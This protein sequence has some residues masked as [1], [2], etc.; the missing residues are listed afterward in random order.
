M[1]INYFGDGCFR[2]QSGD[3]TVLVNPINNRLKGDVV[4]KTLT[5][6]DSSAPEQ[7]EVSFPGEYEFKNIEI[8]GWSIANESTEKFLKTVYAITWEDIRCVFLGH[9]SKPL[10]EDFLDE[11]GEP[12]ILF[13]P[14]GDSHFI[15]SADA[16]KLIKQIEPSVIVPAFYKNANDLLKALGQKPSSQEK[17]V[18]K[19]KDLTG[20]KSEV[21]LIESK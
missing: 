13:I 4:I 11:I 2:L 20:M 9:L 7:E 18:F 16:T 6:T 5:L 19:K 17:F 8:R 10:H 3:T 12:D 1:I 15:D 21:V 14:T